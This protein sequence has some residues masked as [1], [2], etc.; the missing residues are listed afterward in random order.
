MKIIDKLAKRFGYA[1]MRKRSNNGFAAAA[2]SRLLNDWGVGTLAADS[3]IRKDLERLRARSRDLRDNNDYARK[4]LFM[5]KSNVLGESGIAMRNRAKD[6]DRVMG[7]KLIP[8][9][10]DLFANKVINESWSTWCEKENCTVSKTLTWFDVEKIVLE[11]AATDGEVIIR[12]IRGFDNPFKFALQLFESDHL[13]IELNKDLGNGR[14]I[15]MGVELNEWQQP[16]AYHFLKKNPNDTY[17]N[18]Y[19]SRY[20]VIPANEIVHPLVRYRAGQTRGIP[21]MSTAMTRM[22][23]LDKYEE[24]EQ[25]AARV[26]AD[27]M[28]FFE[29]E[30]DA[31]YTGEDDGMGNK[32]MNAEPGAFEVL[33]AGLKLSSWDPQHPNSQ[34]PAFV[35]GCLRGIAAGIGNVSYNTLANDMES[36]N[37]ASGKLGLDEERRG[38]RM[39]RQ[40][41]IESCHQPVFDDWLEMAILSGNVPLPMSKYKKFNAPVWRGC[42]WGFIDPTKE[43]SANTQ[44][45]AAGLTSPQ[46]IMASQQVDWEDVL[47]ELAEFKARAEMLGLNINFG[48]T[49][50]DAPEPEPASVDKDNTEE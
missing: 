1:P 12:K 38:W 11:T 3:E 27:K 48:G 34:F 9:N 2:I 10:L 28:G 25:V 21:W 23:H 31:A 37:F 5:L 7:G 33:P 40:W 18:S 39:I 46:R 41:L 45:L 24:A 20:E 15:R 32:I 49:P 19:D 43:T 16:V 17:F 6:P 50:L 42:A 22:Q 44:Q 30:G 14:E 47:A 8:G 13:D 26:S 36:V 4:F 35:K 29:R